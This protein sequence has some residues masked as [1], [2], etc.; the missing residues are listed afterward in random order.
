MGALQTPNSYIETLDLGA[1]I[2]SRLFLTS[3]LTKDD[4]DN[5]TSPFVSSLPELAPGLT[6][7]SMQGA[8]LDPAS[9]VGELVR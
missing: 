9:A 8:F 4:C 6:S 5:V 1:T 7:L 3:L 2:V